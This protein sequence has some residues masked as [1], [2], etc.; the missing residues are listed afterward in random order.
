MTFTDQ[1][2]AD[3]G[4]SGTGDILFESFVVDYDSSTWASITSATL[5]IFLQDNSPDEESATLFVGSPATVL[6]SNSDVEGW[7][8][9]GE[10]PVFTVDV[11]SG[12]SV[13]GLFSISGLVM[14]VDELTQPD[15]DFHFDRAVLDVDY[16]PVPVPAAVWLFG[17]A[18]AGLGFARRR[19]SHS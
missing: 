6:S 11:L 16:S 17:S 7:N 2:D 4:G 14:A 9:T 12:M 19:N 1:V 8:N 5:R 13:G 15:G 18:I 3:L 10:T